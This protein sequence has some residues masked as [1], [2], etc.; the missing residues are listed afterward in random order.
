MYYNKLFKL[1]V[2]FWNFT[3]NIFRPLN[4]QTVQSETVDGGVGIGSYYTM[5][6]A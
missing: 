5:D 3:F 4:K 6:I 2:Y 1:M